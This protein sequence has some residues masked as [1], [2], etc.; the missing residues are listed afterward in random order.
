MRD[1][2]TFDV[3]NFFNR[4]RKITIIDSDLRRAR[5]KLYESVH[6]F[7]VKGFNYAPKPFD[8]IGV[9]GVALVPRFAYEH[10][11]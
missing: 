2:Q 6:L 10:F 4:N 11:D 1:W 5:N 8:D 3:V 7:L 9:C